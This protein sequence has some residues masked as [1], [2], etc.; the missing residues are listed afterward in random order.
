MEVGEHDRRFDSLNKL[1]QST[2]SQEAKFD[3]CPFDLNVESDP[4]PDLS[5]P[6]PAE[7][8]GIFMVSAWD[9]G[10]IEQITPQDDDEMD[11]QTPTEQHVCSSEDKIFM[12]ENPQS[13]ILEEL[14]NDSVLEKRGVSEE[15]V[16]ME[17]DVETMPIG[18]KACKD[19]SGDEDFGIC[20][21]MERIDKFKYI[22]G[23]STERKRKER[24]CGVDS[25]VGTRRELPSSMKCKEKNTGSREVVGNVGMKNGVFYD[26]LEL[27]KPVFSKVDSDS[28]SEDV[29]FLERAKR[30]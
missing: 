21:N 6:T 8:T 2:S 13:S 20:M 3:N 15:D 1:C 28:D 26:L 30:L 7:P 5:C 27:S 14:D 29:D 9:R 24:I 12:L 19:T 18:E 23:G 22:N 11:F 17:W 4:V 16:E 10:S 25:R